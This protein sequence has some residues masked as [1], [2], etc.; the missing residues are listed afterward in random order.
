[1]A[2]NPYVNKVQKA[3]GTTI[4]DITDTTAVADAVDSSAYFYT[5]AG[6]RTQGTGRTNL[7]KNGDVTITSSSGV[8]DNDLV[9]PLPAGTY[10]VF[11]TNQTTWTGTS[12]YVSFHSIRKSDGNLTTNNRVGAHSFYANTTDR[13]VVTLSGT[14]KGIRLEAANNATNSSGKTAT[15]SQIFIVPEPLTA[16]E[17]ITGVTPTE[18]SLN[19]APTTG[20][21]GLASVQINAIPSTYIGSAVKNIQAYMGTDSVAVTSYTATDVTLTVK[22]AGTYK[23]S[24]MGWRNTTGGTSGSRLYINGTGY[25]TANTTFDAEGSTYVQFNALTGVS[26]AKDDVIVVR[27]RA[28]STSYFTAVGNLIIE[29]E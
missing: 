26:L 15:Y 29:E 9:Q 3:D 24:W 28:R 1:M 10:S 18:S 16:L 27:A 23:V 25:G 12:V 4:I 14:A 22:K 19:I 6:A 20:Y 17:T 21:I 11:L 2:N 13:Q 8:S 5:A 7:W